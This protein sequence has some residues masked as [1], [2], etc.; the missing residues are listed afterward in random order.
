MEPAPPPELVA[1]RRALA[2]SPVIFFLVDASGR[3]TVF[4]GGA[5]ATLGMGRQELVGSHV[6]DRTSIPPEGREAGRRAL[7]GEA[8]TVVCVLRGRS[9]EVRC[10]PVRDASGAVVAASGLAIDVTDRDRAEQRLRESEARLRALVDA[11]PFD[12]WMRDADGRNVLQNRTAIE[13]YSDVLGRT[14]DE[15]AVGEQ[16]RRRWLD[17]NE[18]A[19]A[20]E[21]VREQT[22][23]S[24][25]GEERTFL[26]ILARAVDQGRVLGTVGANLDV[27]DLERARADLRR[28][29]DFTEAVVEAAGSL[30]VV[31]DPSARVVR[32]NAAC[33]GLTGLPR[34]QVLGRPF[35]EAVVAPADAELARRVF[36]GLDRADFPAMFETHVRTASGE[37]RLV[38]WSNRPLFHPDGRLDFVICTGVDITERREQEASRARRLVEAQEARRRSEFLAEAGRVLS[39]S[40]DYQE[41]L[42]TVAE[43]A[44]RAFADFCVVDLLGDDGSLH[45]VAVACGDPARQPLADR[46]RT[47]APDPAAPLGIAYALRTGRPYLAATVPGWVLCGEPSER[48]RVG[49]RDDAHQA[50]LREIP[51][52]SMLAVPL[53]ARRR[54]LGALTFLSAHPTREYGACDVAFAGE[55]ASRAALAVDNARL[56][57]EAREAVQ[58]REEFLSIASHELRT[59]LTS[60]QLCA[61]S[62]GRTPARAS[63]EAE[64]RYQRL[65]LEMIERQG[66]RIARLVD[67]LLD[68]TRAQAGKL[69]LVVEETDLATLVREVVAQFAQ[70]LDSG[71]QRVTVHAPGSI[72]G[73]WDRARLDQVVTNLVSNA[74]KYGGGEPIDVTVTA[75]DATV[76]LEVRDRGQGIAPQLQGRLFERFERAVATRRVS[77]LGL[78][79]YIVKKIVEAHAGRVELTSAPGAGTTVGVELPRRCPRPAPGGSP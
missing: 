46:L 44:V 29:R 31:L 7:A 70:E 65:A 1:L 10:T 14:V 49:V 32:F 56:Y 42:T 16:L 9:W 58:A 73:E 53:V 51:M 52:R 11:L 27:T 3:F 72:P 78:G 75:G 74:I 60:L 12:V 54:T 37:A 63:S 47:F 77:G 8:S 62:L 45:R 6:D 67:T 76:R 25:D 21:L 41:T 5:M 22:T 48:G 24:V 26:A 38:A 35:R 23:L 4:E 13:H 40:L 50:L 15:A 69:E 68:V 33:E 59:P 28:E 57:R 61:Q 2:A 20:G 39:V 79:L 71:A 64:T 36:A 43:L 17:R 55:L 66:R 19:M 30:L 34:A 18:R